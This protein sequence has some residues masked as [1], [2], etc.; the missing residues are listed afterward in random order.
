MILTRDKELIKICHLWQSY[1]VGFISGCWDLL[2]DLH[3]ETLLRAK[4]HCDKLIVGIDSDDLVYKNK[5]KWPIHTVKQR[6]WTIAHQLPVDAT[7]RIT[8]LDQHNQ[9]CNEVDVVFKNQEMI[10]GKKVEHGSAELI[11]I[12]DIVEGQHT[13]ELLN[14]FAG[15]N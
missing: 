2:H 11:I 15:D 5:N 3:L 1:K 9:F 13:S 4:V 7:I 12:P 14:K 8:S 10:Y 6:L